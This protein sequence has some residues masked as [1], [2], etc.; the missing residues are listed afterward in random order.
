ML[1]NSF[2]LPLD[3]EGPV[4]RDRS[5]H[6]DIPSSQHNIWGITGIK[7]KSFVDGIDA[8]GIPE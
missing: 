5:I 4:V 2:P 8:T 3:C 7:K 1:P 6:L